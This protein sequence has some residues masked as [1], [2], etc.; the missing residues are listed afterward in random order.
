MLKWRAQVVEWAFSFLVF[1]SFLFYQIDTRIVTEQEHRATNL[2]EPRVA[3]VQL[4][5]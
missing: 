2:V 4:A 1:S 5:E 3:V